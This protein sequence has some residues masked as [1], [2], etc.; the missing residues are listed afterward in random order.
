ML[1]HTTI[2]DDAGWVTR[3][4]KNWP[5]TRN[6][7]GKK[8][9]WRVCSLLSLVLIFLARIV[10][11]L[12][13][14]TQ[15]NIKSVFVFTLIFIT[16][17]HTRNSFVCV[18]LLFSD[19]AVKVYPECHWKRR[20]SPPWDFLESISWRIFLAQSHNSFLWHAH[21]FWRVSLPTLRWHLTGKRRAG[22][23]DFIHS[24]SDPV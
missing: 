1:L 22:G 8:K 7:E 20:V 5:K 2:S 6:I 13:K 9:E 10:L 12:I 18:V 21:V 11:R 3:K 14:R 17:V 23:R 24:M 19:I 15:K 16:K 4:A